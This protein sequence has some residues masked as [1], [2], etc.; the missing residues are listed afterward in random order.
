M[1]HLNENKEI[2]IHSD[3]IHGDRNPLLLFPCISN[4]FETFVPQFLQ[5]FVCATAQPHN[6]QNMICHLK[7]NTY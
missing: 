6:S 5:T 7:Y 2:Y 4:S 1:I 3:K